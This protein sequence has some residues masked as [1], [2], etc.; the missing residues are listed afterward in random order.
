MVREK[1]L[2]SFARK[3]LEDNGLKFYQNGKRIL[4]PVNSNFYDTDKRWEYGR[5]TSHLTKGILDSSDFIKT[6]DV[7]K[8]RSYEELVN[9]TGLMI[10]SRGVTNQRF[11]GQRA[12]YYLC[13]A[14]TFKRDLGEIPRGHNI[15]VNFPQRKARLIGSNSSTNWIVYKKNPPAGKGYYGRKGFFYEDEVSY[16]DTMTDFLD[17][18]VETSSE[19]TYIKEI[20]VGMSSEDG[21][22]VTMPEENFNPIIFI[23][24]K[25]RMG[26]T[27]LHYRLLGNFY[28]KWEKKCIDL[29]DI[30]HEAETHSTEWKQKLFINQLNMIGEETR[31]LPLVYL[32]PSTNT[33]KEV[34]LSDEVGFKITLPYE[35]VIFDYENVFRGNPKLDFDF[36]KTAVYFQNMLFDEEGNRKQ[37]GLVK[38]SNP[39]QAKEY[40]SNYLLENA[41]RYNIKNPEGVTSKIVNAW[42]YLYNS[43]MLDISSDE[44][45]KWTIEFE[46]QRKEKYNSWIACLIS[47]LVPTIN[48][49]DLRWSPLYP[50]YMKYILED[51]YKNQTQN[52]LF[53]RNKTE[54]FLF[55]NE[56]STA[57]YDEI[58]KKFTVVSDVLDMII[59]ESG[60][61]RIGVVFGTQFLDQVSDFSYIICF[62]KVKFWITPEHIFIIKYY[63]FIRECNFKTNLITQRNFF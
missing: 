25:R 39:R 2:H 16:E 31:P 6:D 4:T 19:P 54:I 63:I 11:P 14:D 29:I 18:E 53:T 62:Y 3:R 32:T 37:D 43:K 50:F 8:I 27:F 12:E 15:E 10:S 59:R 41:E 60:P 35:D 7:R 52:P 47:D 24:G 58:T 28:H 44:T 38:C 57:V 21:R 55:L 40:I 34:P 36:V 42:Q 17:L 22:I 30:A 26:K 33:L 49:S 13:M 51:I 46:N 23:C 61:N 48:I 20:L 1:F 45:A 56:V 9:K 5:F